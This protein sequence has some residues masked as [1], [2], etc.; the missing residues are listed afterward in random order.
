MGCGQ[1]KLPIICKYENMFIYLCVVKMRERKTS[2]EKLERAAFV[3]KTVAHP[4]RLAIIDLLNHNQELTVSEI[5]EKIQ[6][7]QSL[8]S[9]HLNNMK[10]KGILGS[11]RAGKQMYYFLKEKDVA[12]VIDCIENCQ[13]KY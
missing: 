3:L 12:K 10:I 2:L 11:K 5:I 4:A 13:V 7:E 1:K 8:T 9:H 6:L